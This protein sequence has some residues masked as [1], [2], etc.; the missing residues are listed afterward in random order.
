[1]TFSAFAGMMIGL[2]DCDNAQ[3]GTHFVTV[4]DNPARPTLDDDNL[5]W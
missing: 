4:A 1:M 3:G 2:D 5:S